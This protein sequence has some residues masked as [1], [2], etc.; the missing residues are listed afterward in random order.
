[1][2]KFSDFFLK[3]CISAVENNIGWHNEKESLHGRMFLE[4]FSMGSP[5][6]DPPFPLDSRNFLEIFLEIFSPC[7]NLVE[8]GFFPRLV[9]PLFIGP[10]GGIGL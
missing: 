9:D 7:A 1:M 8:N 3:G 10:G 6:Y 5:L 2:V 4:S